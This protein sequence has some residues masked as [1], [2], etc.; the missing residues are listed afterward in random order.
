MVRHRLVQKII[1]AYERYDREMI[2][3]EKNDREK[4]AERFRA[5]RRT[6]KH[7]KETE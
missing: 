2:R 5:V 3:K 1:Q 6:E 7:G 4:A